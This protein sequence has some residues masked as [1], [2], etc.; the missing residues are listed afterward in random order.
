MSQL[1]LLVHSVP[2][3]LSYT[4]LGCM[5]GLKT[6]FPQLCSESKRLT[7]TWDSELI[8]DSGMKK[9]VVAQGAAVL[10]RT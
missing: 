2:R 6:M 8:S 1:N 4:S 7:L 3:G 10:K 9:P 5:S